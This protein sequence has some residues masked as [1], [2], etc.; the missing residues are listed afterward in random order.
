MN[1]APRSTRATL[2]DAELHQSEVITRLMAS[3]DDDLG[4]R[5]ARCQ[6][7]RQNRQPGWPWRCRAAGCWSCRRTITRRWWRGFRIWLDGA[8]TSLALIPFDDD[9]IAGTPKL[10]KGLRDVRDRAA[11][12]HRHWQS[13]ALS[14]FASEDHLLVLMQHAHI[15]RRTVQVV[16]A[17][18]WPDVVLGDV[19]DAEPSAWMAV[20][21]AVALARRRRG[22]EPIRVIIPAQ[23][24]AASL[25]KR[26]DEPMPFVF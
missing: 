9:P 7:E 6:F 17:R 21:D 19:G 11:R 20:D 18:R 25:Q 8:D 5:M 15:D 12:Q 14:G 16:L 24:A 23:M 4:I 10:R 22:V 2:I 26:W 1:R 3:G 13:V